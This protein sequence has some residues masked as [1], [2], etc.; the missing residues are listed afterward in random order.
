MSRA[1]TSYGFTLVELLVVIGII[2]ILIAILLPALAKARSMA[3]RVQCSSNLHQIG[4]GL[5]NYLVAY[6]RLPV[7]E[8]IY[9]YE[10]PHTLGGLEPADSLLKAGGS[11]AMFFCPDNVQERTAETQWTSI[12][13]QP[14]RMT[15]QFPHFV[16]EKVNKAVWLL[17]KPDYRTLRPSSSVILAGDLCVSQ[18]MAGKWLLWSHGGAKGPAGMNQLYADWS[19]RWVRNEN[20][21]QAFLLVGA[22]AGIQ[23]WFWS[24][25]E[26]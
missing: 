22:G 7:R 23:Y 8:T 20:D 26:K 24:N 21:L 15:Y 11:K 25:P 12:P 2:A 1:K 13:G 10:P 9:L 5:N 3:K 17:P 6:R 19:V 14:R 16:E 18:N 4:I